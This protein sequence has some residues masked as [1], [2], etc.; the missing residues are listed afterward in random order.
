MFQHDMQEAKTGRVVIEC[1]IQPDIFKQLLYFIYS[2]RTK[3]P[4]TE[5][6]VQSL[7]AVADKYDIKELKRECA[8]ILISYIRIDN[9]FELLTWA[10]LY[11]AADLGILIEATF[12][13]IAKNAKAICCWI[14]GRSL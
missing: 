4:L 2:G 12:A 8:L 3:A 6:T 11:S 5:A 7:L 9:V 10:H 1:D 13:F 14:I